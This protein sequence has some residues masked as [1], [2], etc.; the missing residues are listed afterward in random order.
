MTAKDI[1]TIAAERK[2]RNIPGLLDLAAVRGLIR[3]VAGQ[4]Y[5]QAFDICPFDERTDDGLDAFRVFDGPDGV[6]I[7]ATSGVAAAAAF[8]RYLNQRCDSYVGPLHRR[9]N[10]PATP[11]AVGS[12]LVGVSRFHYRY[13]F[14]YCT[15][16]YTYAFSDWNDLEKLLDWAMMSGYNLVLNPIGHEK[17]WLDVLMALG[18]SQSEA[19][20][21]IAGPA[22]TPWQWMMNMTGWGGPTQ[23]WWCE[24]QAALGRRFTDR[25]RS[26]GCGVMLPGYSG[27]VPDDFAKRFPEA[28]L[29]GQG[30]WCGYQRPSLLLPDDPMFSR[31]AELFYAYQ[32][33]LTGG[34]HYAHY[35]STDP[36]HEGG[37]DGG[38]DLAQYARK[39]L[40]SM[41]EHDNEAVWFFQGWQGNPRRE[42]LAALEPDRVLVGNL[43]ADDIMDGG[44]NFAE[45]PWLY[46]SVNN[47]GG[48][49]LLRGNVRRSLTHPFKALDDDFTMVGIGY[50]PEAVTTDEV[51][52]DII[53]DI[54]FGTHQPDLSQWLNDY[55]VRRYG[56]TKDLH[57]IN[58]AWKIL[59]D[60]VYIADGITG[61]RE[62]ALLTRPSLDADRV[63]TWG[64][65]L[66]IY[67]NM[68]VICA[69]RLLLE[70]YD[71]LKD[72]DTYRS[73]LI[74]L[75]RQAIANFGWMHISAMR[76]AYCHGN[77]ASFEQASNA[78][79][80]LF[81][82]QAAVV[83]AD[84][85]LSLGNWLKQARLRGHTQGQRAWLEWNARTL[86]TTWADK[87][88]E[89]YLHDYSAREWSGMLTKFYRPRWE[90]FI[91]R[92]H[93]A[94][95]CG[96]S[97]PDVD[98]FAQEESFQYELGICQ[99]DVKCDLKSAVMLALELADKKTKLEEY[100]K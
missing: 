17:V 72:I 28:K 91:N 74:S 47:F 2:I 90:R 45:R 36:F 42:M 89:E 65:T 92:I 43:N 3:R 57:L 86:I 10:L 16:G 27:M 93:I 24:E 71:A 34:T 5:E 46:C 14:N 85:L 51:F 69:C 63:S 66:P 78:F 60:H 70:G 23:R 19:C 6:V 81:D 79:L 8:N 87:N 38:I 88:G 100:S 40:D 98:H 99:E 55:V 77:M 64:G 59:I 50:M 13:L 32:Q 61:P 53:S 68:Q 83:S 84:P 37:N 4:V 12:E 75:A 67:D 20:S 25:L 18:Y 22:F 1:K 41:V 56:C 48:Q 95:S 29:L 35:Y 94:M 31:V 9:M 82:V 39:T 96:T 62:S 7:Q 15:F 49:Q 30:L 33:K 97:V 11:P 80:D 52:F 44:D 58:K 26:F 54:A 21:C 76:E 73:D